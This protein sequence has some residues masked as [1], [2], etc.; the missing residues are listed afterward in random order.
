MAAR[1]PA[2]S[3]LLKSLSLG[4]RSTTGR[5]AQQQRRSAHTK[6]Y[7]VPQGEQAH[8]LCGFYDSHLA[9]KPTFA[10]VDPP[11]MLPEAKP[12][13]PA[14]TA[15]KAEAAPAAKEIKEAK[16]ATPP[17]EKEARSTTTKKTTA[18]KSTRKS[19]A[20]DTVRDP[21]SSSSSSSASSLDTSTDTSSTY[22]YTTPLESPEAPPSPPPVPSPTQVNQ[23]SSEGP[24]ILFGS[25]LN[26]SDPKVWQERLD[27]LRKQATRV[28]GVLVPPKP[29]EP[30]N[31]CMSGCVNCVWDT[32]REE[33]ELWADAAREVERRKG[34]EEKQKRRQGAQEQAYIQAGTQTRDGGVDMGVEDLQRQ[35]V[36]R[37]QKK[38]GAANKSM[39]MDDDGGGKESNWDSLGN[40]MA[41]KNLWDDE[42]YKGVPVGIREFMK[43]EKKLKREEEKGL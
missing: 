28:M 37:L 22:T 19:D 29:E 11:E 42:L 25:R 5:I 17:K 43:L 7:H 27:S 6:G 40:P 18:K 41:S 20:A 35:S 34:R 12:N 15:K 23:P 31:C 9:F 3:S 16:E 21:S 33:M 39:S 32:F 4:S 26:A 14:P 10:R 8:R 36:G 13:N 2:T 38:S 30:D 24:K 1:T